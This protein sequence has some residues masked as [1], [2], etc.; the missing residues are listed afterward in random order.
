MCNDDWLF[1]T[2]PTIVRDHVPVKMNAIPKAN[3]T[4]TMTRR[5]TFAFVMEMEKMVR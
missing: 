4:P 1:Q 2:L 5:I 3:A